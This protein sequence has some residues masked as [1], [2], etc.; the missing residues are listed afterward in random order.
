M[1]YKG[2]VENGVIVLDEKNSLADG[3]RVTV[4]PVPAKNSLKQ[5]RL[6]SSE[7]APLRGTP[8]SYQDPFNEATTSESWEANQ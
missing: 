8:C 2:H 4:L 6:L 7:Q 3:T 5:A 1:T